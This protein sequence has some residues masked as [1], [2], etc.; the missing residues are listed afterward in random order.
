MRLVHFFIILSV[1]INWLCDQR[2]VVKDLNITIQQLQEKI[3]ENEEILLLDVRTRG[4]FEG[5]LGHL[6][7]SLLIPVQ[8]LEQ[9]FIELNQYKEKEIVVICRSGNRSVSATK[10]LISKG[11]N[12]V[13]V[14]GGMKAWNKSKKTI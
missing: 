9:R 1:F 3:I 2:P 14:I 13:N 6:P 11:F 5:P 8:E 12:A 7:G 4:E 10:I